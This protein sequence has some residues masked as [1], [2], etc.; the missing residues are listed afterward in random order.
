M[1]DPDIHVED[2]TEDTPLH[3]AAMSGH[4]QICEELVKKDPKILEQGRYSIDILEFGH[5]FRRLLGQTFLLAVQI[6]KHL[7]Y[8]SKALFGHF[9]ILLNL[10]PGEHVRLHAAPH[11]VQLAA[12][13]GSAEAD[14]VGRQTRRKEQRT[15]DA[16]GAGLRRG[17]HK[18]TY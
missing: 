11:G 8:Y 5:I 14:R 15:Q 1:P 7:D 16:A 10:A 2:H 18:G 12:A 17:Q 9:K 6:F 3:L 4:V 13:G